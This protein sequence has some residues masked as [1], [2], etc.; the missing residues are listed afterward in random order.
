MS[1]GTMATTITAVGGAAMIAGC[2]SDGS[3]T[4]QEARTEART[5]ERAEQRVEERQD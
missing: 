5:A 2:G 3:D 4:R 1:A